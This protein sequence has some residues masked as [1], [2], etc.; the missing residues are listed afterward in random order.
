MA[1]IEDPQIAAVTAL[2]ESSDDV[3]A[4]SSLT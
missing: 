1:H 2:S 4:Q 3:G